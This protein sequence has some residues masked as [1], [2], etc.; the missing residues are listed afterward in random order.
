MTLL[1]ANQP[2]VVDQKYWTTTHKIS[3]NR[4]ETKH[5]EQWGSGIQ[6]ST[7]S[8]LDQQRIQVR[9]WLISLLLLNPDWTTFPYIDLDGKY[10]IEEEMVEAEKGLALVIKCFNPP[11]QPED[12]GKTSLISFTD[13]AKASIS[14]SRNPLLK[15]T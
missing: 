14:K 3:K 13:N 8:L 7:N 1:S 4:I 5:I 11:R 15:N 2:S 9:K 12:G 10:W 6:C